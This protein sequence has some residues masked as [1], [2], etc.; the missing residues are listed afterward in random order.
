[1]VVK[2]VRV[3]AVA[4][5]RFTTCCFYIWLLLMS[6]SVSAAVLPEDRAD[7]LSHSYQGGG[8][9]IT[10]PSIL[11]RKGDDKTFSVYANHYVDNISSASID[12][13]VLGASR[14]SEERVEQSVGMDILHGKTIMSLGMTNSDENDY[15]ASSY[16][17]GISTDMF[18]DLTTITMGY[19]KGKDDIF[20][21]QYVGG[22]RTRESGFHEE[23]IRQSYSIGLS[24]I[25]SK[26]F[27]LSAN[28]ETIT[29]EGYLNN[30]YRQYRFV[31]G[32]GDQYRTEVYPATR[33]SR[34]AS[35]KM[36]YFLPYRAAIH[37]KQRV[38]ADDWGI[39]ANDSEVGYTHPF[40]EYLILE[41][42]Y[43]LYSQ[44]HADFYSDLHAEQSTQVLD[45]RA[46][47][48]EL[49]TFNST[50][51]GASISYE[52]AK[53]GWWIFDKASANIAY[54]YIK[55]EYEDFR[56]ARVSLNDDTLVGNEP[57]YEFTANVMQ[58][59][60]SLWY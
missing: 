16:N 20:R 11:V 13:Q 25:L 27:V 6:F 1:M 51:L 22:V 4:V 30:P 31:S 10:G 35:I 55:F 5:T 8:I 36:N 54:D 9:D 28:F 59:Y 46:R 42:R 50:T 47:D 3:V 32:S 49:S 60:I 21:T 45:F 19:A 18:G 40:G 52:F 14:Y 41:L 29:D 44:T 57:L 48:K 24:Q 15:E 34:A 23:A 26:N 17:F 7:I 58:L 53:N 38:F 37:Y 2:V 43:R 33:T 56:D 39:E 12:V